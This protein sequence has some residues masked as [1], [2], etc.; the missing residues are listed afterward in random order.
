MTKMIGMT[1]SG[2][3]QSTRLEAGMTETASMTESGV[4]QSTT[5]EA[6]MTDMSGESEVDCTITAYEMSEA[7]SSVNPQMIERE[8]SDTALQGYPQA[9]K[10]L[11]E[12][13]KK[14][15]LTLRERYQDT[16]R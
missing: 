7:Q 9:D 6:G 5:H 4:A 11:Q 2:S 3:I 12:K 8:S 15:K 13:G 16:Q 14:A 1:G 10:M